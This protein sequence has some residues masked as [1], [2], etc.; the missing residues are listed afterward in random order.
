HTAD[1]DRSLEDE[2]M[3]DVFVGSDQRPIW[4]ADGESVYVLAS[5]QGSTHIHRVNLE[6]NAVTPITTGARR[7]TAFDLTPE[8]RALVYIA[9]DAVTPFELFTSRA[10]GRDERQLSNHNAEFMAEVELSPAQEIRFQSQAGDLEIQ[11]WIIKPPGFKDG[12][13]YPL[14]VQI[15]GG[16]HA[17]YAN[18]LFHEMQLMAARGYVVLFTNPRG[19]AG[20][21]REDPQS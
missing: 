3:S 20:Y 18:A 8:G 10:N 15:H 1:F 16:P 14:I 19:S 6:G 13:K 5:D 2:G 9:G 17:M 21:G 4:S 7:L 11:G 12:V